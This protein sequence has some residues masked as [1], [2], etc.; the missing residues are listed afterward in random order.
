M[1]PTLPH[2]P[3]KRGNRTKIATFDPIF[4]VSREKLTGIRWC[5]VKRAS[6]FEVWLTQRRSGWGTARHKEDA[7]GHRC[8]LQRS[9]TVQGHFLKRREAW[10]PGVVALNCPNAGEAA[11]VGLV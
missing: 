10:N 3:Q 9:Q 8:L 11:A 4:K 5:E 2:P 6:D 7:G 1:S